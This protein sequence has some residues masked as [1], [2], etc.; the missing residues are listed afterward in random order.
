[1]PSS[2]K[3]SSI[4]V[5]IPAFN[6]E[7]HIQKTLNGIPTFVKKIIVINDGSTD[8]TSELL[9]SQQKL[10]SRITIVNHQK[11]LGLGSAL[12]TGY[13][14]SSRT[15]CDIT[16]VM[17]GDNQMDP[18]DLPRL[19]HPI[20]AGKADYVKGN[21]LFGDDV[22]KVMPGYRFVGNS[23]LTF[24]T[25]FATGYWHVVDPQCG[26]TAIS[27]SALKSIEIEKLVKGYAYNAQILAFLNS[28]R[29]RVADIP[30]KAIYGENT[31]KI[32]LRKYIPV[33]LNLLS[34][35]FTER[36]LNTYLWRDFHPVALFYFLSI[37]NGF[38]SFC[39]FA[40]FVFLY[41]TLNVAPSTTLLLLSLSINIG[42]LSL[43]FAIWMDIEY[44]KEISI[45]I[46][47]Q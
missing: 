29:F 46:E 28:K 26:Y 44:N 31:S 18:K 4:C 2:K 36:I 11:N 41:F 13:L 45:R 24:L 23:L 42:V 22:R 9:L 3:F 40:R 12:V 19:V 7:L 43:F 1:M 47:N 30:V 35:L 34:R 38:V 6:E 16:V 5:I 21:R 20:Q 33:V 14:E 25:K 10:D 39:L 8:K 32:K 27:N 15:E 17:A 37:F